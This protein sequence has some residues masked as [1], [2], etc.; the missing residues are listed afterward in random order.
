MNRRT[1]LTLAGGM[2]VLVT[3]GC[4][5]APPVMPKGAPTEE[6]EAAREVLREVLAGVGEGRSKALIE[7]GL[8]FLPSRWRRQAQEFKELDA[9][10][11][12]LKGRGDRIELGEARVGGRWAVVDFVRV[13]GELLGP[14]QAPW[15]LLYFGGRWRW[16]PIS[17]MKD[18]A[19]TGM[20]DGS[21]DRVY[22][23]W[24]AKHADGG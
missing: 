5:E 7:D 6:A 20:M 18:P 9:L 13:D 23:G 15:F 1:W 17:I 2:V 14:A 11:E 22:E 16:M 21:F 3:T 4:G 8:I 12:K 19:V 10:S 24:K